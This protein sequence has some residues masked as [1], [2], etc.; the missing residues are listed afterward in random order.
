MTLYWSISLAFLI[1]L[2]LSVVWLWV[3][4]LATHHAHC[5]FEIL[6]LKFVVDPT[7]FGKRILWDLSWIV[8]WCK[9]RRTVPFDGISVFSTTCSAFSIGTWRHRIGGLLCLII[10]RRIHMGLKRPSVVHTS[11]NRSLFLYP[12]SK[13]NERWSV[14]IVEVWNPML[15]PFVV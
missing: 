15:Y 14:Q 3:W 10:V 9:G 6:S 8:N 5:V 7:C 2:H 11:W 12:L 4:L 13:M 1:R